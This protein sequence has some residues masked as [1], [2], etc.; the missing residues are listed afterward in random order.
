MTL[1]DRTMKIVVHN[2]SSHSVNVSSGVPQGSV[3]GPLF[4][5]VYINRVTSGLTSK[6]VL[7]ADDFK[8]YLALPSDKSRGFGASFLLQNDISV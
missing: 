1:C 4:F 2:S 3:I 5:L 6:F 7:F 8:L